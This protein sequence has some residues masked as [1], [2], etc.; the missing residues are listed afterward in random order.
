MTLLGLC[1]EFRVNDDIE[2]DAA[3]WLGEQFLLEPGAAG[4]ISLGY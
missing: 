2:G 1:F 4:R 3:E